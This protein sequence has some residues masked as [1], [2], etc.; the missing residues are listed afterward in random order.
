[1]QSSKTKFELRNF[2]LCETHR[3]L[4]KMSLHCNCVWAHLYKMYRIV[5][6]FLFYFL[7]R[8]RK[9]M[10]R[11]QLTPLPPRLCLWSHF[12]IRAIQTGF[13]FK[14]VIL[15]VFFVSFMWFK[16][17]AAKCYCCHDRGYWQ[18]GTSV[19]CECFG[20]LGSLACMALS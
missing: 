9:N 4:P 16:G 15:D 3:M 11:G 10:L 14:E 8:L 12:Q 19:D 7:L 5:W 17:T 1:M 6:P 20:W 2:Y 13:T 18:P